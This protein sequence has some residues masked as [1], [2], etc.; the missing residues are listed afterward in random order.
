MRRL[1]V[2]ERTPK[3]SVYGSVFVCKLMQAGLSGSLRGGGYIV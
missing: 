3:I 2:F 1:I